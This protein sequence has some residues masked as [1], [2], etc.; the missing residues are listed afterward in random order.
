MTEQKKKP[1]TQEFSDEEIDQ[2]ELELLQKLFG[3]KQGKKKYLE[4]EEK[5]K[6]N[7]EKT[8][9]E[10]RHDRKTLKE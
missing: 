5:T 3:K 10:S 2:Q 1:E 8:I 6:K 7:L 4:I 9:N